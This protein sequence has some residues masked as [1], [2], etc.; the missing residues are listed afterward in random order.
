MLPIDPSR[1]KR[2][3]LMLRLPSWSVGSGWASRPIRNY[4]QQQMRGMF[5]IPIDPV[6]Y[7]FAAANVIGNVFDV[8]HRTCSARHI[9]AGDVETDAVTRLELIS[10]R[11][12]L[13]SVLDDLA[14]HHRLDCLAR[15]LMVRRPWLGTLVIERTTGGFQPAAGQFTLI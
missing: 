12:D 13:D 15:Q 4:R 11:Q 1:S 7:R 14:W 5:G 9:H 6:H 3:V 2:I 8:R 10:R